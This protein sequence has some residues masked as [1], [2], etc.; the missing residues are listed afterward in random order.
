MSYQSR[1]FHTRF[2]DS[3]IVGDGAQ[4]KIGPCSFSLKKIMFV[5]LSV[6]QQVPN[7]G[8]ISGVSSRILM[9]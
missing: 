1:A 9:L 3:K 8:I 2:K 4:L 7:V 6:R 5:C